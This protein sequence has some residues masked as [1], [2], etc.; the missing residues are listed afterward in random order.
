MQR[1]ALLTTLV[2]ANAFKEGDLALGGTRDEQVR[3]NAR[4]A[5]AA[6]RVRDIM[7]T[8]CVDDGVSDALHRALHPTLVH[9]IEH[10]SRAE[11]RRI[12]L[13]SRG[14]QSGRPGYFRGHRVQ[15]PPLTTALGQ[16]R[17]IPHPAPVEDAQRWECLLPETEKDIPPA[18]DRDTPG[19]R[20]YFR[21]SGNLRGSQ[22]PDFLCKQ[23][24]S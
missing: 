4:Q 17:G 8:P 19:P 15:L 9:D 10:L 12:L 11:S 13:G 24:V 6:L 3:T 7:A 21:L 2:L 5:L 22:L 16:R 20:Q 23:G 18:S 1:Q 14:A